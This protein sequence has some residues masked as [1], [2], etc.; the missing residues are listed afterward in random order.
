M[1]RESARCPSKASGSLEP[2]FRGI[3]VELY[4][5]GTWQSEARYYIDGGFYGVTDEPQ[6]IWRIYLRPVGDEL[7]V[8]ATGRENID[9]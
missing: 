8:Y 2:G 3:V 9:T 6:T 4:T 5:R 1:A 7:K